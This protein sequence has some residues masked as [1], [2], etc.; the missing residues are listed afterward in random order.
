MPTGG[1]KSICFQVPTLAAGGLCL[2]V[3]P[4][5]SLMNDQVGQLRQREIK[6]AAVHSGMR[7]DDIETTLENCIY[8]D[9][10]FLY[11]SPERIATDVFRAKL[12]HMKNICMI[13]VDEAHCVSQWGYDFRP[14]YLRIAELRHLIPYRVPLLAL[15]ATATPRV[16]D[17]IQDRLEFGARNVFSMSFERKNLSYVVRRTANKMDEMVHILRSVTEGSAIVYTR[18]RRLTSEIARMLE[19]H[20]I[21]ADNYHAG[22]TDVERD[23][24]Q[25]NWTKGRCRVMVATNAFGMGIDKPDVRIVIHYNAPDS[26]EAYFQE[27]GRAGRDGRKAYAVLLYDPADIPLLTRRVADSFPSPD[28]VRDTYENVCYFLQI[29]IGEGECRTHLF[30]VDQFCRTFHQFGVPTESALRLLDNAGYVEYATERDMKSRV[31][32][33]LE[34]EELYRLHEGSKDEELLLNALLR[35]YTGVFADYVYIEELLLAH[36]TGFDAGRVYDMLKS[37]SDQRVLDFI[38]HRN[39]PTLALRMGRV[40]KE[41]VHL[42]PSVYEERKRD[43]A[44]RIQSMIAY[45]SSTEHCRSRMLLRY[46][47]E[48]AADD[49]GQCDVCLSRR[50]GASGADDDGRIRAAV[51]ALLG[52]GQFHA[53]TELNTLCF[54]RD[55]MDRVLRRMVDEEE[56][57]VK[58]SKI[59]LT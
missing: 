11:V 57:E 34:K 8:G 17:D 43:Y 37:L 12:R 14:S 47:G 33:I 1:G 54:N 25:V 49:C 38:P 27:A 48:D 20:G 53:A 18:N 28:Y 19:S 6:A 7:Q 29:G 32:I 44:A 2:V 13:C 24:R 56:M 58:R 4:L 52:D 31:R 21:S 30:S 3:T 39:T 55:A 50:A 41:Q 51:R 45:M 10:R 59:R 35:N 9:Y 16:V 5:I 23:L 26:I 36:V 46:F 15:T 42:P 40:D 22:L